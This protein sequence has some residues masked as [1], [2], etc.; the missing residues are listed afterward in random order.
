MRG[1]SSTQNQ[2]AGLGT[3]SRYGSGGE[4]VHACSVDPVRHPSARMLGDCSGIL[5]KVDL[6]MS[7]ACLSVKSVKSI[8]HFSDC[9]ELANESVEKGK[10]KAPFPHLKFGPLSPL[11]L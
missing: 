7:V 3:S 10:A 1:P 6:F 2:C 5:L 9:W 11:I 8:L 4:D